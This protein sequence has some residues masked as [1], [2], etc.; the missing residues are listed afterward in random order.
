[1]SAPKAQKTEIALA[2]LLKTREDAAIML[3]V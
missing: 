3:E 2:Q 1:M